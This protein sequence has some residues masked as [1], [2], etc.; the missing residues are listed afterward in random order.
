MMQNVLPLTTDAGDRFAEI[1]PSELSDTEQASLVRLALAVLQA[2][3]RPGEYLS[4]PDATRDYLRLLLGERRNEVFGTLFL[5]NRHRVL[6]V[7]ELFQGTLDGASVHPRVVVQ[8]ALACNAGAVIFYHNHPSGLPEPS[9]ADEALT[10]KLRDA[11]S[12]IEVRVLDH[13]VV[14]CEGT[15]SFAERGLL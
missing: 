4:N 11:L 1:R 3:H 12:L 7:E 9:R 8:R 2:R 5:D 6:C 14:G 15:V 10:R 13:I